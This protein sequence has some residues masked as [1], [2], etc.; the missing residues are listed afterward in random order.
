[1]DS[2]EDK[3][4]LGRID[5]LFVVLCMETTRPGQI[6]GWKGRKMGGAMEERRIVSP[7]DELGKIVA[8]SLRVAG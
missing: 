1:M 4:L 8:M 5:N 3:V 2:A 7:T 6:C